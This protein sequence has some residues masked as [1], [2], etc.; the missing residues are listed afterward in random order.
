MTETR[1]RCRQAL[2]VLLAGDLSA[3]GG[4]LRSARAHVAVC[5]D[6]S[7][8]LDGEGRD[9]APSSNELLIPSVRGARWA[10]LVVSSLQLLVAIPW[11]FGSSAVRFLGHASSEHLTRDGAL[12]VLVAC[13]GLAVAARPRLSAPMLYV[14]IAAVTVQVLAG[15]VDQ[16][17]H[18]VAFDYEFTHVLLVAVVGFIAY[19]LGRYRISLQRAPA[20]RL[21]VVRD[22][23]AS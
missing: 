10:L 18:H 21:R 15:F 4:D 6:C 11:L 1:P 14:C 17:D 9:S 13:A 8:L 12:G 3:S 20:A 22:A 2:T 19:I 5:P 16:H 7:S 23:A